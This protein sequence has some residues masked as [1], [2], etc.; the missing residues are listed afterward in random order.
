MCHFHAI[1]RAYRSVSIS[2]LLPSLLSTV[3]GAFGVQL[4]ERVWASISS[5]ITSAHAATNARV[6]GGWIWSTS[7]P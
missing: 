3:A 2:G 6:S 5:R 1:A 4:P 7:F